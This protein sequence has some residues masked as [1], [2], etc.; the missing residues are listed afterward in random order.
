[1]INNRP[2][3]DF[4]KEE[5]RKA[6]L[7]RKYAHE[8][9]NIFITISTIVN[10]EIELPTMNFSNISGNTSHVAESGDV[11]PFIMEGRRHRV[12]TKVNNNNN[13]TD[14]PF[15]ILK[16]LCEYGN[17][18][19]KEMNELGKEFLDNN[20]EIKPFNI[21][22]AIDFCVD[23]FDAKRK[24]D[25]EKRNLQIYSDINFSYDKEIKSINE[26]GFKIVLINLLTNS[27][28]FTTKGKIIVRAVSIPKEKKI[29]ILLKDSGKGFNP[30]KFI[31]NGC[32]LI[33]K[34]NQEYNKDGSGL[35]LTIVN[36]I[37]TKFD[38][39]LY[40]ISSTEKGGTLF[41]FDLEDSYPYY[42]E[43]NP[44]N[45]MTDSLS[46]MINDINS[47][48]KD[49]ELSLNSSPTYH[50]RF[51]K[52]NIINLNNMNNNNII[53][54]NKK[55]ET[56]KKT[57]NNNNSNLKTSNKN[58]NLLNS[59]KVNLNNN[60]KHRFSFMDSG[61]GNV[62]CSPT[63]NNNS[64]NSNYNNSNNTNSNININVH[65]TSEKK[66]SLKN[67]NNTLEKNPKNLN[68]N[69]Y[70]LNNATLV[71]FDGNKIKKDSVNNNDNNLSNDNNTIIITNKKKIDRF[72]SLPKRDIINFNKKEVKTNMLK[73]VIERNHKY[74][75]MRT[76]NLSEKKGKEMQV[77]RDQKKKSID[78]TYNT[79]LI[80]RGNE[81]EVIDLKAVK[82]EEKIM[83]EEKKNQKKD[84][85]KLLDKN[86]NKTN[87]Y[88]FELK[89]I[90]RKNEI[91]IHLSLRKN[92]R[93]T[94]EPSSERAID[95]KLKT[96]K[97]FV[98]NNNN[99]KVY[100]IICDDEEFVARSA[101]E[102]IINYYTKK[103]KD[104]HVYF[105]P[106]GIECL[107]L[108]YK[109]T[110]IQN[111]K[112]E[113]ILMDLEMPYLN[114]IKTCNIIK[115]IQETNVPVYILSGDEPNGCSANGYC[116]KPLSEI[117]IINKLD[118]DNNC[119]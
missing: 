80:E 114:G 44:Q 23:V 61:E 15:Y 56:E 101:R 91:Y 78:Y 30:N 92:K 72:F 51:F 39:K 88:L 99:N 64:T 94:T 38:I 6:D 12:N 76:F 11:S 116:N 105:T 35:G 69:I 84:Y 100:I 77:D 17:T 20:G 3:C 104:P 89:K 1:M 110:I 16:T 82:E 53:I 37:L 67:L 115:S 118:K 111:R 90:F 74:K 32:F 96:K 27:Y 34:E 57:S 73:K 70:N 45:L 66:V 108:M 83:N 5:R 54:N 29:R 14:S 21:S 50:Q 25:K 97:S 18:L 98:N 2:N 68:V 42:D 36:E 87:F 75:K 81:N 41:Y 79:N 109:L 95:K 47:G 19:V 63:F 113:Y 103:G 112:I 117:D 60:G 65:K 40:C 55:V 7:S 106:N 102:L 4:C 33:F 107:Y 10:T 49:N 62:N 28:K 43:I 59:N 26:L 24:H 119:K 58:L 85:K 71:S 93:C 86:F 13:N 9:K 52:E 48:K 8:L 22:K 46:Q 31:Q